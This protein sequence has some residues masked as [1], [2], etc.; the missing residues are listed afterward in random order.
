[1]M[2]ELDTCIDG[3]ARTLTFADPLSVIR[4]DSAEEVPTALDR[5]KAALRAGRHVAGYFSYEL[6][7]LLEPK[8]A[9]LL[10]NIR[11]VPLLWAG[12]FESP[13][14]DSSGAA[15]TRHT[16]GRA[17][18]GP[19]LHEW[20][21]Q[22]YRTR[23]DKVREF[24]AA[25]DVYQVNLTFRSR[26]AFTGSPYVLYRRLRDGARVPYSAYIDDG[27]R[28]ILS[29]S[30]ELFFTIASSGG[31]DVRPMK[32]TAPRGQNA[33]A[34]EQAKTSLRASAKE[35]A[36][37]LMIVDLMRNDLSQICELGS[38]HVPELFAV[39]TYPTLHQMV[40][41]VRGKLR[42]D[43]A[44]HKILKALFPCGSV[45]GA[46]KI[47]AMEI[48]RELEQSPRGVY[49][50]AIGHFA[51]DGSAQFNVAIRTITIC[52]ERGELGVGGAVVQDSV[53]EDEYAECLLKARYFAEGRTPIELIETLRWCPE[54]GFV[55]CE[56]HLERVS[57]S[58]AT[59]GIP[60]DRNEALR[61]LAEA[62]RGPRPLRIRL[63][64]SDL[65]NLS[66]A[67]P[68]MDELSGP[69]WFALSSET[70]FSGDILLRHKTSWRDLYEQ[71][72]VKAKAAGCDEVVFLNER[73]EMTEGS[74]T[75][76]FVLAASGEMFTPPL[77]CGLLNGCL[78][79]EL[80]E[81]GRCRE[82]ILR[83]ADLENAEA[84]YLGNSLRG[85]MRAVPAPFSAVATAEA[86]QDPPA[87]NI[88]LGTGMVP[89]G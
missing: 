53:A 77:S 56:R 18:A 32:G 84:I 1:M 54:E 64:L 72:F 35:R 10:P 50:G 15:S 3:V 87:F 63:T 73:G 7:Y 4:V 41:T 51:P 40:S 5:I 46:P 85:L 82:R 75:N 81:D 2:V 79:Q 42:P 80:I 22:G 66:V 60:F 37:N 26:F 19:L 14:Q 86:G 29:L 52:G 23:F 12:I 83:A 44:P 43:T 20:N 11:G 21:E 13:A 68:P 69:W 88:G 9:A 39:E 78:R 45:T 31:V 48:I 17:Y 38:V 89:P 33:A 8:L 70:T 59:F 55:R 76:L 25:G 28:Q 71:E 16:R 58:A 30:P 65:G 27:E 57:R 62:G 49:C 47:R 61:L 34:D 6:G 67:A 36:E 24:I 74:R